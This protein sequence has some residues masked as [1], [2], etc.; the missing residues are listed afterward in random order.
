M[1][2]ARAGVLRGKKATVYRTPDSVAEMRRGGADLRDEA[3][4]ADGR[5]ITADGPAAA[6]R[7]GE[8]ILSTL[9]RKTG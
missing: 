9:T 1:V 4:V 2:L 5:F 8:V 7:F 3:V 6:R